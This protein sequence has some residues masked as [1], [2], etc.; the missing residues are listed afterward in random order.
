MDQKGGSTLVYQ[1]YKQLAT[2]GSQQ[3]QENRD[4]GLGT[5]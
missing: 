2:N 5:T 1:V 3:S 4:V